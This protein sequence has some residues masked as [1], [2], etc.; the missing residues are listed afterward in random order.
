MQKHVRNVLKKNNDDE[1]AVMK[2]YFYL[3]ISKIIMG[4]ASVASRDIFFLFIF[5]VSLYPLLKLLFIST[6]LHSPSLVH[7][8]NL[9]LCEI[10][11]FHNKIFH[12][13]F[14]Y[15]CHWNTDVQNHA[16]YV[17]LFGCFSLRAQIFQGPD[18]PDSNI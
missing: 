4:A 2:R 17:M 18:L 16:N 6:S 9:E 3:G 11:R 8:S 7:T 14:R 1:S 12:Y 5:I 10:L 15:L 13:H